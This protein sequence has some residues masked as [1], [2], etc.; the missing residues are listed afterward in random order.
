MTRFTPRDNARVIEIA[1]EIGIGIGIVI[2]EIQD[3]GIGM[4][5]AGGED[6]QHSLVIIFMNACI[7][8]L[9]QMISK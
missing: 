8:S 9:L 3:A 6:T 7:P 1:V 2:G 4:D 5:M